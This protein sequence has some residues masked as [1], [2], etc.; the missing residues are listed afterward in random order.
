M[1]LYNLTVLSVSTCPVGHQRDK[2]LVLCILHCNMVISFLCRCG[3]WRLHFLFESSG[4]LPVECHGLV[5]LCGLNNCRHLVSPSSFAYNHEQR[6]WLLLC[7]SVLAERTGSCLRLP[8]DRFWFNSTV[9]FI[10]GGLFLFEWVSWNLY[11][12]ILMSISE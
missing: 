9:S 10:M 12:A 7:A 2:S 6:G 11:I 1:S 8:R 4:N 5:L 3:L